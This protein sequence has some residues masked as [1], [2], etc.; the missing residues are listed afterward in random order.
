ML[1]YLN[2]LSLKVQ[3]EIKNKIYDDKLSELEK[4]KFKEQGWGD[5]LNSAAQGLN[6]VKNTAQQITKQAQGNIADTLTGGVNAAAK[7][8]NK[9]LGEIAKAIGIDTSAVQG[10]VNQGAK[11]LNTAINCFFGKCPTNS[12]GLPPAKPNTYSNTNTNT[13]NTPVKSNP[14]QGQIS[15]PSIKPSPT[16]AATPS[17]TPSPTPKIIT[18]YEHCRNKTVDDNSV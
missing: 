15:N 18:G 12:N 14:N 5:V 10:S 7:N 11:E 16:T 13:N 3:T 17:P 6:N 4:M 1:I 9:G 8:A 2:L